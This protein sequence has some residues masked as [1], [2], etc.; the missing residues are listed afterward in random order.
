MY[1]TADMI[2]LII[3]D[4]KRIERIIIEVI[5]EK[6]SG[7][8]GRIIG[9][10]EF[11]IRDILIAYVLKILRSDRTLAPFEILHLES[12][13]SFPV[14]V[15]SG[16]YDIALI[17]GGKVDRIDLI[18]GVTRIVD[19]KT[20]SVAEKITSIEDLFADTGRRILMPGFRHYSIA[21]HIR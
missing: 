17:A 9:G 20:G 8:A 7:G 10:N 14:S 3:S 2:D 16:G 6:F 19:Y 11:I 15:S 21:K 13:F 5:D 12:V 4:K 1:L 18:Q